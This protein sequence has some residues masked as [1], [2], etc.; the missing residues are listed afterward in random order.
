MSSFH[1]HMLIGGV[2]GLAAYDLAG[3]FAPGI[4][5]SQFSLAGA[6]IPIPPLAIGVTCVAVSSVMAL[7][8]DL[9][10]PDSFIT[11]AASHLMWL[12][13]GLAGLLLA[14]EL[15]HEV[16]WMVVAAVLGG[17]V[18]LVGGI[19][20]LMTLRV[21]SL[22]HR[23]MTHSLLLA[24][25]LAFGGGVLYLLHWTA[26]AVLVWVVVWGELLHLAGDVVTPGGVALFFPIWP[27]DIHLVPFWF[28][29]AGEPVVAILSV[30]VGV[31]FIWFWGSI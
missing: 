6:D 27:G 11:H 2:G 9:D 13:G 12:V 10:N 31:F 17:I 18:G 5:P 1:T 14:F 15:T 22:G 19:P 20:I 8:P 30:L 28:A 26:V 7:W 24:F 25:G 16:L 21:A 4:V 23:R 29:V 3:R